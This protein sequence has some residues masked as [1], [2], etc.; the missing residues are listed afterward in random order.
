MIRWRHCFDAEIE[1]HNFPSRVGWIFLR[2][3]YLWTH[4]SELL[5]YFHS[6]HFQAWDRKFYLFIQFS[7]VQSC[8]E[9]SLMLLHTYICIQKEWIQSFLYL[10]SLH[11]W[12]LF[13]LYPWNLF[14][15]L[16]S[17][18]EIVTAFQW[19]HDAKKS[20]SAVTNPI[21]RHLLEKLMFLSSIEQDLNLRKCKLSLLDWYFQK[22]HPWEDIFFTM[23]FFLIYQVRVSLQYVI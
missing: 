8:W 2:Q 21:G 3:H 16:S 14:V 10:L 23:I 7:S 12:S 18:H 22:T 15:I 11:D 1:F 9:I 6:R 13:S 19:W 4:Y 5:G 20:D 17:L